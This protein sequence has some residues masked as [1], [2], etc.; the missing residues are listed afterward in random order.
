MSDKEPV[1]ATPVKFGTFKGVFTPTLL[2]ILG[3]I[4][5]LRGPW[6]VGNA[7]VL[8]A[9]GIITLA[10]VI[11]LFT[12]LSMS[13]IVTNIRIKAGGAFA[14][15]AQS[16]GLE[17]GGAIGIPLYV[18]QALSV[19]MYIFGFREGWLW[20]F[21][22][23]PA[24]L[25]DLA[26][27]LIIFGI[28]NISANA[29]FKTQY[30]ILA[31]IILSLISIGLSFLNNPINTDIRLV[32]NFEGS[33]ENNFSGMSFWMVFAVYFPA[34]TGIM[35]GANMSGELKDPRVSIP[36]G[37][38]AAVGLSYLIYVGLTI[39]VAF[40]ATPQELLTN[41]NVLM[42]KA[43]FAPVVIAGLLGAT[44]SSALASLVGAPRILQALGQNKV[45]FYNKEL[46]KLDRKGE[47]KTAF[48]IT[49]VIV[50]LALLMRDLNAIAPILTMFFL[51]TYAMINVVVLIEQGLGQISF[52]PT[53]KVPIIVPLLGAIGCFFVMF[54]INSTLGLVSLGI[55]A[56]VYIYLT[57]RKNLYTQEGDT[58]SGM[59]NSL[60]EWSAKVVSRLPEA[61]ERAWQPN[62]L[63]PAQTVNDVVRSYKTIYNL[64]R[65]KGSVKILGFDTGGE[66]RKLAKRLPELCQAFMQQDIS[67]AYAMV[68]AESY[69]SGVL[70]SMQSLKASFFRPNTLF[71]SLTDNVDADPETSTLLGKA[72]A[73]GFGAYLYV[74]YGK[75]GLGLEKTINL[76]LDIRS[77]DRDIKFKVDNI[78]IGLL[79]AYL[80][81]RNW[82][83]EL[84]ILVMIDENGDAP[85]ERK[86]AQEY[87]EKLM[88][89][90]R[91]PSDSKVLYVTRQIYQ[92]I[93]D[94]PRADLNIITMTPGSIDLADVRHKS[95]L[96]ETSILCTLDSGLENAL[97]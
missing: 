41:Y 74:A 54:I 55:V 92:V 3:V 25:V 7:G 88:V 96:F 91:M 94:M 1:V 45:L 78:N 63:V 17:A 93:E 10:T 85:F 70:T 43:F 36:R 40:I 24:I 86:S 51:I 81:K 90:A 11:T 6:V 12:S 2:T 39:L 16:L 38:L 20:I 35:V 67:A 37:T 97:A 42:D 77:V 28:T 66:T 46:S 52:R 23:H 26:S 83:A 14:I 4:M 9:I 30:V 58:R 27:F 64:A 44:F 73:Y 47:P 8:G 71:L 15:I 56:A 80:L 68:H 19:V 59:F 5:Y 50:V 48:Y 95:L 21:P 84:N 62:L 31:V 87:M 60:A 89:L 32:G 57:R 49:C 22:D 34:V 29:A 76:W 33:I 72:R 75:V 18:A 82:R 13:S 79:T 61:S 65:P 53:L 69:L